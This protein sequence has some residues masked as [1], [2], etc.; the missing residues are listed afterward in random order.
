MCL[1]EILLRQRTKRNPKTKYATNILPSSSKFTCQLD[2]K[3]TFKNRFFGENPANLIAFFTPS[4]MF[5]N[6]IIKSSPVQTFEVFLR[7]LKKYTLKKEKF[8]GNY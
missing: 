7:T 1:D 3:M 8:K 6:N 4:V 2:L 5:R